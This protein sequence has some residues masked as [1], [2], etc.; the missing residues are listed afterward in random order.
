MLSFTDPAVTVSE[1]DT[2]CL[3]MGYPEWTGTEVQKAAAILRGQTYI[4]ATYNARWAKDWPNSA[5]PEPA[6][7]AII[8]AA[9][10][11]LA[12]PGSLAPDYDPTAQVV[13]ESSAVGP[14][15]ESVT[16]A[17]PTSAGAARK[18][19]P[20]IDGLLAGLIGGGQGGNNFA[21]RRG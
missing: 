10:R 8:E 9:L 13:A 6:K 12:A 2:R 15:S 18:T 4:A 17:K 21:I 3:A 1:A 16:Y 7:F 14:L 19:F 20:A 11:E 5:A